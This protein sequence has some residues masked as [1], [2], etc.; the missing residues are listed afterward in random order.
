MVPAHQALV[1]PLKRWR[2]RAFSGLALVLGTVA[3]DLAFVLTLDPRGSPSSHSVRGLFTVALPVVLVLHTLAT[4]L[5]LPWL[6]RHLPGG[7]PL[8]LHVLARCRPAADPRSLLRVAVSGLVGAASHVFLDGFTHGDHAGWA[9]A[10]LPALAMPVPYPGGPAPLHDALQL[11]LTVA[12]GG[13]ALRDWHRLA[14]A[15]PSPGPGAAAAWEIVAAPPLERRRVL[16]VLLASVLVGAAGGPALRGA[17]GTPDA[18]KLA[19]YGA[20]TLPCLAVVLGAAA[21]RARGAPWPRWPRTAH[22]QGHPT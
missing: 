16:R 2:P 17:L 7:A 4:T 1:L 6:L 22:G 21:C 12:L 14:S 11:W 19:A 10:V 20:I 18:L 8:H 5:V 13:L 3:P 9:L 15:L